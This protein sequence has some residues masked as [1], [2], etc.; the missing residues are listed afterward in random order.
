MNDPV[1]ISVVTPMHNE[2]ACAEEFLHRT[3]AALAAMGRSYEIVAV[4]DGSTDGTWEALCGLAERCPALH[5][6]QLS[7]NTGQCNAIY[8]GIQ[9]SRG[10]CVVVM[11]ADLQHAPEEIHLLVREMDK[12]FALVS[13]SRTGRSES[14]LLRRVP[15]AVA[16]WM[17]RCVTGCPVRD[18]GGFKAMRGDVARA[19]QLRPGQHRLLPALV[20]MRGGGVSEVPV[21]APPRFAGT[22][23]YGVSRSLDVLFDIVL[24]WFQSSF[25]SRPMYLFGR[26][27][28][29]LLAVVVLL[30]A[31][32]L[33]D[34]LLL[35]RAL[36]ERPLFFVVIVLFVA[37]LFAMACGFM[38][39]M[40]R[41]A[42]DAVRGARPYVVRARLTRRSP[43]P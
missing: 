30:S 13:G 29:T 7:R 41:D 32:L 17:L 8:A 1:A 24:L 43:A 33:Y 31:W 14:V 40:L 26:A 3:D 36:T 4:D 39:E 34:K 2:S 22:S 15:S 25:K 38:L 5:A 35:D 16:N 10:E 42:L 18:M 6:V 21:S 9:E 27:G 28:L 12:G 19:L 11:D 23:H 37:A 20:W